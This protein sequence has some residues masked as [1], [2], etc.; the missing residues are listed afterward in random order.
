[1]TVCA[2]FKLL[3]FFFLNRL[4]LWFLILT[5]Y[6]SW[7]QQFYP[8][9]FSPYF[10]SYPSVNAFS[11][12]NSSVLIFFLDCEGHH[13]VSI[14]HLQTS[15]SD[16]F[17][18]WN[19]LKQMWISWKY[20]LKMSWYEQYKKIEAEGIWRPN[21]FLLRERSKD[22]IMKFA[23]FSFEVPILERMHS[24]GYWW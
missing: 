19:D 16:S 8:L 23:F 20:T 9:H 2:Q 10:S 11:T 13:G 4:L 12:I 6:C 24:F 18:D 15:A 22:L 5:C 7:C 1:M 14:S 17:I 21:S 3:L